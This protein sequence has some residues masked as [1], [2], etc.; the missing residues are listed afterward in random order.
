MGASAVV[1]VVAV[2]A[3]I[4]SLLDVQNSK[5]PEGLKQ[6]YYFVQDLKCFALSLLNVHMKVRPI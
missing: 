3:K 5:D 2:V 6:F 1:V 4:G